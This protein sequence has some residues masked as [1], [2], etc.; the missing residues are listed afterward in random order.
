M[1]NISKPALAMKTQPKSVGT[2]PPL[3]FQGVALILFVSFLSR[4]LLQGN[5]P[6]ENKEPDIL[7]LQIGMP[8]ARV[9]LGSSF[10]RVKAELKNVSEG[11]VAIDPEQLLYAWS[12]DEVPKP[13]QMGFKDREIVTDSVP[14]DLP[15]SKHRTPQC[16]CVVLRPGESIKK[17]VKV[18][19]GN[20]PFFDKVG[21]F[22]VNIR[23]GVF[24]EGTFKGAKF[25]I[26]V[27]RSNE[28]AFSVGPC[29]NQPQAD[30]QASTKR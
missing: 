30:P 2:R 23:Y 4:A 29:K 25:F 17:S 16:K 27:V 12:A 14:I 9:C 13:D 8:H 7:S 10:V 15:K 11:T 19:L 18:D 5:P 21:R 22:K 24:D 26:G 1:R 20:P 3:K 28:F 6:Q